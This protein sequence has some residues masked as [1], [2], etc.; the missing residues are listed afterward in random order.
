TGVVRVART[1][2]IAA[3]LRS[4]G[5]LDLEVEEVDVAG[6]PTS[7]AIRAAGW[8]EAAVLLA[9]LRGE[10]EVRVVDPSMGGRATASVAD[11]AVRVVVDAGAALDEVVLRSY[12]V[13]AA[14]QALGWVTS[15]GLAVDEDG[16]VHDRTIRSFGV[17]RAVDTPSIEVEVV[18]SGGPPVRAGDAVFAAVAGAV[19]VAQ[20]C[21]ADWPTGRSL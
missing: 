11:G 21:P 17:L 18:D 13:G 14:H 4:V 7:G 10:P 2:G 12:A 20:G 1:A 9:G 5:G 16:T 8:A 3:A 19:W 15:E 6:P